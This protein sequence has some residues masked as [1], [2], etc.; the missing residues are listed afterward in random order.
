MCFSLNALYQ[1]ACMELIRGMTGQKI[2][3][4]NPSIIVF[5]PEQ[6]CGY[7]FNS[8]L[9]HRYFKKHYKHL[10]YDFLQE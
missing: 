6:F 2:Q 4:T 3:L 10:F 9:S 7:F 8:L 1:T 5:V